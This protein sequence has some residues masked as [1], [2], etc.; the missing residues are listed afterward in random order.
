LILQG[1]KSQITE[2][3]SHKYQGNWSIPKEEGNKNIEKGKPE[4]TGMAANSVGSSSVEIS[5]SFVFKWDFYKYRINEKTGADYH[6]K[7]KNHADNRVKWAVIS[8][9]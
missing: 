2:C 7:Y 4:K 8:G 5:L 1:Y 6:E 9:K 3:V